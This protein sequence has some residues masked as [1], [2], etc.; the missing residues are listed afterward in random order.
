ML[1]VPEL[2]GDQRVLVTKDEKKSVLDAVDAAEREALTRAEAMKI[3]ADG[4]T[5]IMRLAAR[6]RDAVHAADTTDLP[7]VSNP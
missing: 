2:R 3:G 4:E 6:V 5:I 7:E 1:R